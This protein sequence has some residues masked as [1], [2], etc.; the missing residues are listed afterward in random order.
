MKNVKKILAVCLVALFAV[1]VLAACGQKDAGSGNVDAPKHY[2]IATDNGFFPFCYFEKD[3]N[4]NDDII[5]GIDIDLLAAIAEDQGFTYEL[6]P[7]GFDSAI[8]ECQAG[9]ADGMIAGASITQTRI[10]MGWIFSDGYY[11]DN[12]CMA[13]AED[14][15]IT[16]FDDLAGRQVVVKNA[17]IS[18]QYATSLADQYNFTVVP[19]DDDNMMYQMVTGGQAAACFN[20]SVVLQQSIKKGFA[21]KIVEGTQN[22]GAQYGFA[23]HNPENQDLL[24]LFNAGLANVKA[25]G[26]YDEILAKYFG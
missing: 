2:I 19:V 25:N 6:H 1:G 11:D 9:Q 3:E 15:N 4:G 12:Q 24:D 7:V 20:D 22:E 10:E 26:K 5:T 14:S 17:T 23:I 18:D 13:V 16:G 8:A 21:L